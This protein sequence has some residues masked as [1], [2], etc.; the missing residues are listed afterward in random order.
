[1]YFSTSAIINGPWSNTFS[2]SCSKCDHI[3]CRVHVK[4]ITSSW[5]FSGLYLFQL[6][7]LV[8][9]LRL[10]PEK[11]DPLS[12][13]ARE[14][15]GHL[16]GALYKKREILLVLKDAAKKVVLWFR[17]LVQFWQRHRRRTLL[18]LLPKYVDEI[19]DRKNN[20]HV[21]SCQQVRQMLKH[22]IS[23][24]RAWSV[25]FEKFITKESHYYVE[26]DVQQLPRW[27]YTGA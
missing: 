17:L 11:M 3:W 26:I 21:T 9:S 18:G 1:M 19:E 10:I 22:I 14:K 15:L 20:V 7:I 27:S 2:Q 25:I 8:A 5:E 4:K 23:D 6:T 12:R 13:A 24:K 16:R